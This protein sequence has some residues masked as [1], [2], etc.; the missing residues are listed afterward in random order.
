MVKVEVKTEPG[1][2]E[3]TREWPSVQQPTLFRATA[4]EIAEDVLEAN[5]IKLRSGRK[6]KRSVKDRGEFEEGWKDSNKINL[7]TKRIEKR[8]SEKC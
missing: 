2:S 7:D 3:P 5:N 6:R 8:R 4:K 1:L